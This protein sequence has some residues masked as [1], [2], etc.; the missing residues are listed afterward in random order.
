MT[1]EVRRVEDGRERVQ[2]GKMDY[3]VATGSDGSELQVGTALLQKNSEYY[4]F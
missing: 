3:E 4:C 1:E 2:E